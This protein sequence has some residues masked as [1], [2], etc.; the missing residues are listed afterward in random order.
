[1]NGKEEFNLINNITI[2]RPKTQN[3]F[4]NLYNKY[5]QHAQ[6]AIDTMINKNREKSPPILLKSVSST[7][8]NKHFKSNSDKIH[9]P[10]IRKERNISA[11]PR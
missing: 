8:T 2:S 10:V 1:M 5:L 4:D 7:P 9:R 11:I 6:Q 3:S